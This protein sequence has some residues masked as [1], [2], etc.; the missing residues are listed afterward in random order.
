[1]KRCFCSIVACVVVALFLLPLSA[2]AQITTGTVTGRVIDSTGG[3]IPGASVILI[4][5]AQGTR[6]AA[7]LTNDS[8]DY[9]FPN[10]TADTYTIEVAAPAFKITRRAGI[11]VTGGDRVGVPPLTLEVGGTA[12]TVMVTAEAA[13]VQTQSGERSFAIDNKQVESLP[14]AHGNFTSLVAFVP[15]VDGRD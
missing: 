8:G 11:M 15:G 13:L 10:V 3:V 4:S 6:S 12:E 5:E 9:V 7:V 14:V 2:L 1:M